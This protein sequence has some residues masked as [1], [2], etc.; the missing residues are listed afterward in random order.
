LIATASRESG[1]KFATTTKLRAVQ[2]NLSDAGYFVALAPATTDEARQG[3]LKGAYVALPTGKPGLAVV[4]GQT[5]PLMYQYDPVNSL[6]AAL[7]RAL[8]GAVRGFSPTD[9]VPTV[10][11]DYFSG[12]G[13]ASPDGT[14]ASIGVP[15]GGALS[16]RKE[17]RVRDSNGVYAHAFQRQGATSTGLFGYARGSASLVSALG[18]YQ[19]DATCQLL[20]IATSGSAPGERLRTASLQAE[21]LAAPGLAVT[22]RIEWGAF[23]PYPVAALNYMPP[24]LSAVRLSLESSN[25][26]GQRRLSLT[27]RLQL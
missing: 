21:H 22:G 26:R 12:R 20:L 8:T 13:G 24:S 25:Q 1:Q 3:S 19:Y 2:L 18:T 15:F 27:G 10:R 5:S 7:P 17:G 6:T 9:F 4:V 14:Y 16:L 23:A 11:A